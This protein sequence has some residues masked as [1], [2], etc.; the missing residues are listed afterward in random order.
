MTDKEMEIIFNKYFDK[1]KEDLFKESMFEIKSMGATSCKETEPL[2]LEQLNDIYK[3]CQK[4][5]F[6]KYGNFELGM[7]TSNQKPFTSRT[8]YPI[9]EKYEYLKVKIKRNKNKRINKKLNKKYGNKYMTKKVKKID[10]GF[11]H[12]FTVA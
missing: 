11:M 8:S 3:L 7:D 4:P 10:L 1:F 2:T 5:I 12:S 9:L 6:P